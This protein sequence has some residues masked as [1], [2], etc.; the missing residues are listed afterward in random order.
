[1]LRWCFTRTIWRHFFVQSPFAEATYCKINWL[2]LLFCEMKSLIYILDFFYKLRIPVVCCS[3]L[4]FHRAFSELQKV[5]FQCEIC[6][7]RNKPAGGW[8]P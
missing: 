1:M 8:L 4:K 3:L 5:V 6:M 2:Q 7:L